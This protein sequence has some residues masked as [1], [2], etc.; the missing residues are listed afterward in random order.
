MALA[1]K[2]SCFPEG[3][4]KAPPSALRKGE[5]FARLRRTYRGKTTKNRVQNL[6]ILPGIPWDV[7]PLP[8]TRRGT[9]RYA[10]KFGHK[11]KNRGLTKGKKRCRISL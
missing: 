11:M 3:T 2:A 10:K 7:P 9:T 5:L 1:M 8:K 4:V 6:S